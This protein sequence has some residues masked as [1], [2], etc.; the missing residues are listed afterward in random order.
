MSEQRGSKLEFVTSRVNVLLQINAFVS[1]DFERFSVPRFR[2]YHP[3][4]ATISLLCNSSYGLF[5][6][7]YQKQI[8]KL[9]FFC[10]RI[11][12]LE[13]KESLSTSFWKVACVFSGQAWL[14]EHTYN[15]INLCFSCFPFC[16]RIN[17][18]RVTCEWKERPG[19]NSIAKKI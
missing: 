5:D 8:L 1:F 19:N 16:R 9:D 3:R 17:R 12:L 10:I 14:E 15:S 11:Y 2:H 18:R 7:A 6:L 4:L 13:W